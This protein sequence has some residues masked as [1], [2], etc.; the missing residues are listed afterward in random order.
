M[1][2]QLIKVGWTFA[3]LPYDVI[4]ANTIEDCDVRV[5]A[6][7][8]YRAGRK[9]S[10]FPGVA[11][12][13][14]DLSKSTATIKRSLARLVKDRWLL[15]LRRVGRSSLSFIF[16]SRSRCEQFEQALEERRARDKVISA[17]ALEELTS[18]L[19]DQLTDEP[20][21]GSDMSSS[22]SS[23]M[24]SLNENQ[25]NDTQSDKTQQKQSARKRA[26]A[27]KTDA[28]I[29]RDNIA[30]ERAK[31][32]EIQL[33]RDIMKRYPP[34]ET[35]AKVIHAVKTA[36]ARGLSDEQLRDLYADWL[37]VSANRASLVW[38]IEWAITGRKTYKQ[39]A[40]TN[41]QIRS[42]E[43]DKHAATLLGE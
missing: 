4:A 22:I 18:E 15:R 38:L 12:I 35:H 24:S 6:Y 37:T 30:A 29:M 5:Y 40:S 2:E 8:V 39:Q 20:T 36:R 10:S 21:N 25:I 26:T 34:K 9:S 43:H 7:L 42:S 14:K 28:E 33:V 41:K 19:I 23:D 13:A 11:R 16:D 17:K 32:E 27:Q 31:S 1:S 3:Q